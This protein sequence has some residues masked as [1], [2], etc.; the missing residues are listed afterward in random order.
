MGDGQTADQFVRVSDGLLVQ[1]IKV[2]FSAENM[3][4]FFCSFF[5]FFLFFFFFLRLIICTIYTNPS[6]HV[7]VLSPRKGGGGGGE[8]EGGYG[9]M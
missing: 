6:L 2:H 1:L 7:A 8:G 4:F 9:Y 5:S 3:G